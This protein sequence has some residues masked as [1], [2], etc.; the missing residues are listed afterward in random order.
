[1]HFPILIRFLIVCHVSSYSCSCF[2]LNH[3]TLGPLWEFLACVFGLSTFLASVVTVV[4]WCSI[5]IYLHAF[6]ACHDHEVHL[7]LAEL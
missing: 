1:M 4:L 6:F 2:G 3:Q 5:Y 7:L